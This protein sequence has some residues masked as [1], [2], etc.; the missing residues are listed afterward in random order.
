MGGA[1]VILTRGMVQTL[2]VVLVG[3]LRGLFGGRYSCT[4]NSFT[5][6][7]GLY[8]GRLS[9]GEYTSLCVR[10]DR[11]ALNGSVLLLVMAYLYPSNAILT[12]VMACA[13]L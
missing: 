9:H 3:H 8:C 11:W 4:E 13:L 7:S 1:I 10:C 6:H 2:A 5:G 12:L